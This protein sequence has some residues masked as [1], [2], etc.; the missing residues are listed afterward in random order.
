MANASVKKKSFFEFFAGG[1]M[2][3]IGLGDAWTCT[4]ANDF[5][6]Q[7]AAAYKQNFGGRHFSSADVAALT[8][9]DLP[10][11]TPDLVWA[12]FPCQ[13][14]SLAGLRQGMTG[15][16]SGAFHAFWRLMRALIEDNRQPQIIALE[17]VVGFLSSNQGEDFRHVVRALVEEGYVATAAVIDA[18]HFSPQSRKRVF[19]FGISNEAAPIFSDAAPNLETAPTALRAAVDGL[20]RE[21]RQSWR[22]LAAS[23]RTARNA[24]LRDIIEPADR[25][26][27]HSAKKTEA[28]LALMSP[29]QRI[30]LETLKS[31]GEAHL[32]AAFRRVRQENG[33]RR[34]RFEARFDGL[35]G[36]LRTPAGGSSRQFIVSIDGGQVRTRFIAPREAARLMGLPETYTLPERATAALKLCGDGV[37]APVVR[38]IDTAILTPALESARLAA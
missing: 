25:M 23:P 2:A 7:K 13:D 32:G 31:S 20:D 17:N 37:S 26:E 11:R 5:D 6:S 10:T 18:A 34:Q 29:R 35:A 38:W 4:F 30:A 9:A 28:L 15:A 36:C 19:V 8:L 27:W 12:S 16:R 1:G 22:W 21:T 3:R 14:L 24:D 33:V